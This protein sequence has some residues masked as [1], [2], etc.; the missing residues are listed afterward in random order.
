MKWLI[1]N[2]LFLCM[3]GSISPFVEGAPLL[4]ESDRPTTC[5]TGQSQVP[6]S[7]AEAS[8]DNL[9]IILAGVGRDQCWGKCNGDRQSCVDSCPGWDENN[10]VDPKYAA[11]K[12]KN[13]CDTVLSECK[14][15]CPND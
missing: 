3:I 6:M 10:V 13:A 8:L 9:H 14:S 2:M 15:R 11:R 12:C 1:F 7:L 4:A 5:A